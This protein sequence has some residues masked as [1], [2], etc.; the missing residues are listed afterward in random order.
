M[1][2]KTSTTIEGYLQLIYE[3]HSKKEPLK[4]AMIAKRVQTTPS[5]VHATL[6]RMQRDNL[7]TFGERKEIQLTAE[8]EKK[9]EDVTFRH[10]LA[11]YFLYNTLGIPWHEVHAHAHQLEHAMTPLVVEKLTEFLNF[12]RT[13]PHG[14][15]MPGKEFTLPENSFSLDQAEEGMH[16]EIVMI[17]ESLE[18]SEKLL[19]HLHEHHITPGCRH[20]VIERSEV[21]HFLRLK[22][23]D[24]QSSLPFD[25]AEKIKVVPKLG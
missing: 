3:F 16:V 9:A 13:C 18:E 15:P 21:T 7:I 10:R 5:T 20:Q 11:E 22:S 6:Q 12:P 1:S 14:S 17:D 2:N 8:G 19:K 23:G 24:I 25:I 4:S